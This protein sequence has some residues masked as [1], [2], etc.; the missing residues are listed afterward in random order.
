MDSKICHCSNPQCK[1]CQGRCQAPGTKAVAVRYQ[2]EAMGDFRFCQPC[3]ESWRTLP[4]MDVTD[5]K[6]SERS[7]DAT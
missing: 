6:M 2:G 7:H 5:V 1:A 3:D 4:D